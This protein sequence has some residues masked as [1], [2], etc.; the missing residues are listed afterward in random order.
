MNSGTFRWLYVNKYKLSACF[1][2]PLVPKLSLAIYPFRTLTDEHVDL[3][4]KFL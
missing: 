4:L 2:E 3:P 1:S